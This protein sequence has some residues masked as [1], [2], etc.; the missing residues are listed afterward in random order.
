M[1]EM[2]VELLTMKLEGTDEQPDAWQRLIRQP[3]GYRDQRE[4]EIDLA[5]VL[6]QI[7]RGDIPRTGRSSRP[8][9]LQRAGY[10]LELIAQLGGPRFQ[11]HLEKL[12]K[13]AALLQARLGE[14]RQIG[15]AAVQRSSLRE[16]HG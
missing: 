12:L 14:R 7:E 15:T 3:V 11:P 6:A 1:P 9:T 2:A 4:L 8:A 5:A 10:L 13:E 16:N